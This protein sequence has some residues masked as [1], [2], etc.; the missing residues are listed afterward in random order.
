MIV[1]PATPPTVDVVK[2][3]GGFYIDTTFHLVDDEGGVVRLGDPTGPF[4]IVTQTL[5]DFLTAPNFRLPRS[6]ET[7]TL[8]F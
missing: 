6:G 1:L 5:S 3:L 8:S 7:V 2:G 4:R